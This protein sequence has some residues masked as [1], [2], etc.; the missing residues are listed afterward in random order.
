VCTI[1]WLAPQVARYRPNQYYLPH[2][3]AF[4]LTTEPGRECVR[5]G[6]QRVATVLI[7]LNNV[8][9]GEQRDKAG[10]SDSPYLSET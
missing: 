1:C 9:Q 2:F 5:S 3:D 10:A 8:S 7:Y 4:D 6:G